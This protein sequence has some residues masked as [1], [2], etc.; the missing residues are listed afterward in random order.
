[1]FYD[2]I[3]IYLLTYTVIG[4]FYSYI[5]ILFQDSRGFKNKPLLVFLTKKTIPAIFFLLLLDG[6]F[7]M[8]NTFFHLVITSK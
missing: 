7:C 8:P 2:I 1:M 5:T 3:L 6:F 4:Y